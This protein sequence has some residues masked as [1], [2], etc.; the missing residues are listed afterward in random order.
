MNWITDHY[1]SAFLLL[2]SSSPSGLSGLATFLALQVIT[3]SLSLL[4]VYEC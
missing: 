4:Q 2:V 3:L 1:L